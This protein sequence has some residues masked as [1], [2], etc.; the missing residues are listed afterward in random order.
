MPTM[1]IEK[2]KPYVFSIIMPCYNSEA[3]ISNAMDSIVNQTYPHWE[4]IAV[5][6]GSTDNTLSI[7]SKYSNNDSRIKIYS[8]ENGGYV[9]AVNFALDKIT[10]DYFLFLGSDDQLSMTLFQE[11]SSSMVDKS[12]DCIAF[13]SL[14]FKDGK[15]IGLDCSTSF[16]DTIYMDNCCLAEYIDK[17]PEHSAIFSIRDTS[18]C[19]KRNLLKDIRYFGRYGIDADGIFSMLICHNATSFMSVPV[20]GY[21]WTLRSDSLSARKTT[22]KQERDRIEN[23]ISFYNSIL[24]LP[25]GEFT[26][27]ERKYLIRFFK[28]VIRFWKSDISEYSDASLIKK[29]ADSIAATNTAAFVPSPAP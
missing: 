18:K 12:P 9:S 8:K 6:D 21:Y 3:Y 27:A 20:D 14:Q 19:Y 13:R 15:N 28:T 10:G 4:L 5:N 16:S 22:A 26:F 25:D 24:F 17:Y 23:W 29:A 11:L 7:L 2:E 1:T